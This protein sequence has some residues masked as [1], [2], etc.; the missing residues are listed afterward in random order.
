MLDDAIFE[1]NGAGQPLGIMNS[2]AL[3]TVAAE[4]GQPANTILF[5]NIVNMW[6]RAYGRSRPSMAWLIN[7][8]IEPQLF[9]MSLA[10]A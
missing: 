7:Q 5:E 10:V 8:D 1:G 4:V 3:V 2:P 6:S 9:A